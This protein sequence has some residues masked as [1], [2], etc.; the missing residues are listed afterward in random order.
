RTADGLAAANDGVA[1]PR[2]VAGTREELDVVRRTIRLERGEDGAGVRR[3]QLEVD[4]ILGELG[5]ATDR[6]RCGP[7]RVDG[8][9]VRVREEVE[10]GVEI[11]GAVLTHH[12]ADRVSAVRDDGAD[13]IGPDVL[14][15]LEGRA[16][17]R[18]VGR[19]AGDH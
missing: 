18:L 12:H 11:S 19:G 10:R 7:G 1:G 8:L 3:G 2:S 5:S 16:P 15:D 6:V 4:V 9:A 17:G 14:A 13:V